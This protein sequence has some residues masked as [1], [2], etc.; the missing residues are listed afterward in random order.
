[1]VK[2]LTRHGNSLA[3]VIDRGILQL[4]DI[5]ARTK[6]SITTDGRSLIVTPARESAS[7]RAVRDSYSRMSRKYAPALKKLA[8]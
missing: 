3:L 1:M 4:L 8:E 5:D 6:L 2:T 7:R